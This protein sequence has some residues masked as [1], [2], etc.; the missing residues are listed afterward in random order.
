MERQLIADYEADVAL[1]IERLTT[2]QMA[3]ALALARLPEQIRGF[4]HVK[5]A[6][7]AKAQLERKRLRATLDSLR[8][9]PAAA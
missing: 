1:I 3:D 4:G 5:A 6:N 8:E 7:V 9:V 2:A